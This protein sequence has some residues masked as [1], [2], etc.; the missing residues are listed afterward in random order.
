ME[1][2]GEVMRKP[3]VWT[4]DYRFDRLGQRGRSKAS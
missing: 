2:K 3:D 1:L 4:A